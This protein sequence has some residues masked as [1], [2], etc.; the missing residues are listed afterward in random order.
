MTG[1]FGRIGRFFWYHSPAMVQPLRR[2]LGLLTAGLFAAYLVALS[3]HLVHHL[4]DEKDHG[5]PACPHF[6][7]NQQTPS[8]QPDSPSLTPPIQVATAEVLPPGLALPRPDPTLIRPRAPPHSA[9][10][11]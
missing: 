6:A 8:L 1:T 7:Q 9:P 10:S 2:V 4:F 5:R 11:V 3:P